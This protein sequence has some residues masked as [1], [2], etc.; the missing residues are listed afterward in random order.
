MN[1]LLL[2]ERNSGFFSD[3]NLITSSLL[4]YFNNNI[5]NF[6]VKWNNTR[7]Q[8]N[9]E[10]LFLK[11][12]ANIPELEHYDITHHVGEFNIWKPI[13]DKNT[14]IEI[15]KA[16]K[17]FNY[18]ENNNFI[19]AKNL[20]TNL[21]PS[22]TLGVH[23]R[24]TDCTQHRSS[25][26]LETYFYHIEKKVKE[27][28][29]KKLFIA[30]DEESALQSIIKRYGE[31]DVLYNKNIIRSLDGQ[32]IHY[33]LNR[34][35]KEKLVEDVILDGVC[36]SMCDTLIHTASNVMGYTLT[37]NPHLPTEQIDTHMH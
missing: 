10:N 13:M 17:H 2:Q 4:Y 8:N 29:F 6:Y 11:Y 36:L 1:Y 28:N 32:P 34:D 21:I 7:Y 16:V 35:N 22:N 5:S 14:F 37:L 18:F 3:F 33:D 31:K 9:N 15:H 19:N 12:F 30:T 27:G 24:G 23:I 25:I 26:P 20:A